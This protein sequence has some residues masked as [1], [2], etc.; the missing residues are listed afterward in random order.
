MTPER[1]TVNIQLHNIHACSWYIS[2][3]N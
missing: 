3:M 2:I 1:A